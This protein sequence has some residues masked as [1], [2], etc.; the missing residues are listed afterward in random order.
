VRDEHAFRRQRLVR[1][2]RYGEQD[3]DQDDV[4]QAGRDAGRAPPLPVLRRVLFQQQIEFGFRV[5]I[6]G[7]RQV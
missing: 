3:D 4:D 6:G 1:L 2:A 7:I 5:C